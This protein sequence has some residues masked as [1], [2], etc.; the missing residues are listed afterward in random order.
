MTRPTHPATDL[1]HLLRGRLT[2]DLTAA[3]KARQPTAVSTLRSLMA[4]I[5]NAEAVP[6]TAAPTAVAGPSRDVPR[7]VLSAT[8]IQAILVRE[9]Y[10]CRKALG[11]YERLGQAEAAE[12]LRVALALIE[13]YR[14]EL[15]G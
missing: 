12:A 8:D 11:D 13:G 15:Y 2:A 14:A 9:A 3:M 7:K 6:I 1:S 10:E 5:D 4:A